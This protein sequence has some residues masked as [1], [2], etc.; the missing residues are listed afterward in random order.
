MSNLTPVDDEDGEQGVPIELAAIRFLSGILSTYGRTGQAA[1]WVEVAGICAR[2]MRN[3]RWSSAGLALLRE[4]W[5]AVADSDPDADP[6]A[7]P[8]CEPIDERD[9][10]GDSSRS[11]GRGQRGR[12]AAT[13]PSL[14]NSNR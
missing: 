2:C 12:G 5:D 8:V 13:G 9:D 10:R 11:S 14:W 4:A 1:A 3:T 7:N 6:G